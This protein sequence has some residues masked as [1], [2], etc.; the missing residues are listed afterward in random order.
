MLQRTVEAV[1]VTLEALKRSWRTERGGRGLGL[2][3][4]LAAA[5]SL[6]AMLLRD[7]GPKGARRHTDLP[8]P[9]RTRRH[10]TRTPPRRA[11]RR[12]SPLSMRAAS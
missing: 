10:A 12:L 3:P 11:R 1:A 2:V 7:G 9:T 4:F 5:A 6:S 8:C